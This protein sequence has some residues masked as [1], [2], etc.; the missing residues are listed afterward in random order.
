MPNKLTGAYFVEFIIMMR[1]NSIGFKYFKMLYKILK[2][3]II[4]CNIFCLFSSVLQFF[5]FV[6]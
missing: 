4:L 2:C 5:K 3:S 1:N 6:I